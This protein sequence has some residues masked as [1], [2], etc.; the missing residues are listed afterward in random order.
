MIA[1]I[2]FD[3]RK[4]TFQQNIRPGSRP[5]K[6]MNYYQILEITRDAGPEEIKR[7]YRRLALKYHPDTNNGGEGAELRFKKINEAYSILKDPAKRRDYDLRG[8]SPNHKNFLR[9]GAY[10][11]K[12]CGG[13]G[14]RCMGGG[15]TACFRGGNTGIKKAFCHPFS[16]YHEEKGAV[17]EIHLTREEALSGAEKTITVGSGAD[18]IALRIQTQ[19]R[20][21]DGDCLI[22]KNG[23]SR[24]SQRDIYLK[25]KLVD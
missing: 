15:M 9:K 19:T 6:P 4:L 10:G 3:G 5:M 12:P 23:N 24:S 13:R 16:R 18:S 14:G 22:V 2:R 21:Q 1:T 20:L 8:S 17:H 7:A 25:V 11:F